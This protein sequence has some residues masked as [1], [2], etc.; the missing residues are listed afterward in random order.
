MIEFDGTDEALVG[1]NLVV[2]EAHQNT[3]IELSNAGDIVN[4]GC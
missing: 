4:A 3:A 2:F 1:R